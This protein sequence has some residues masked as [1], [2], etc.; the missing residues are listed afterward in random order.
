MHLWTLAYEA[1]HGM[2]M[3]GSGPGD[4]PAP[5]IGSILGGM[6]ISG[7]P[8][9]PGLPQLPGGTGQ[10]QGGTGQTSQDNGPTFLAKEWAVRNGELFAQKEWSLS[11]NQK[12]SGSE[13]GSF[14]LYHRPQ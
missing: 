12:T 5:D 4:S 7:M 2:E 6:G 9:V 8:N 3:N 10:S 14:K 11:V 1:L 13:D